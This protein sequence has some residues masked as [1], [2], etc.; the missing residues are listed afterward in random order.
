MKEDQYLLSSVSNTLEILDL[1]NDC[2]E[3]TLA[4][5]SRR[6]GMGK[7]SVFRMLYTLESKNY[8]VRTGEG[9]YRLGMKFA[10]FGANVS[11][12]QDLMVA[13]KPFLQ[14]LRDQYNET[15]HLAI[16]V[17]DNEIMF[18]GKEIGKSSIRMS[19]QIG[20]HLPAYCTGTGKVLLAY[21]P[22]DK[23]ERAIAK[24]DFRKL[25]DLTI[26][27]EAE[28][29]AALERIRRDGYGSDI[30]ESE[31]GLVCYAAPVR[32]YT[33]AVIAAVSISGPSV[34]MRQSHRT[35]VEGLKQAA[36][37]ASARLGYVGPQN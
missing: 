28:L 13:L 23:L 16:L 18:V 10:R 9:R 34:R 26:L 36:A 14:R 25:T 12:R 29:R 21:L 6:L 31:I 27:S 19:S 33:G 2:E 5:I 8:V 7:T 37:E 35:L 20:V 30:E 15:T 22:P 3:L 24:T 1:L 32:N 11:E 17:N 4:E